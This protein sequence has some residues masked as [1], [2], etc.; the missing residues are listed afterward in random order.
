MS[1]LEFRQLRPSQQRRDDWLSRLAYSLAAHPLPLL[2]LRPG[3]CQ[4]RLASLLAAHPLRWSQLRP[5]RVQVHRRRHFLTL[6]YHN[7]I[8]WQTEA[9]WRRKSTHANCTQE[10]AAAPSPPRTPKK[11]MPCLRF[12]WSQ[13]SGRSQHACTEGPVRVSNPC[14]AS[15][16]PLSYIWSEPTCVLWP[17][18]I[19][20]PASASIS[21]QFPQFVYIPSGSQR[22]SWR[23]L[24]GH[25]G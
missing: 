6:W 5:L 19:F 13:T 12:T 9:A 18:S 4:L 2:Q 20:L 22:K 8:A 3:D 25:A 7:M 14:S 15:L 17:G 10:N 24:A 11:F 16:I 21:S 1:S 23:H